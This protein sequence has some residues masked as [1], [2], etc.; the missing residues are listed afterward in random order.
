[1]NMRLYA[2][3]AL[4]VGA[5]CIAGPLPARAAYPEKPIRI[6]VPLAPGGTVDLVSRLLAKGLSDELGQSVIVENKPGASGLIGTR[7]VAHA[8]PDGYTLLAVANTF[9]SAPAFVPNA[10][11]DPL[12]D[13]APITQTCQIPMVLVAHPSVPQ[14]TVKELIERARAHPG[15][16]SFASSGIGSTGY[17]AAEL[18]SRQAGI[19]LLGVAYKGNGQALTDVVGGQVMT[20]FDQV[21]TSGP[22][23]GTNKLRALA[24]TTATRSVLLPDVPTIAE[25]GLP[26][27]EDVTF[28]AILAP[29]GTPAAIV[30]QLHEAI[31]KVLAQPALREQLGGQGVEVKV[32][33]SPA[34]FGVYL[35]QAAQKY[36]GIA[37]NRPAGS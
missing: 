10:G 35:K 21:S 18:F 28:N 3:A 4:A 33:D 20:M 15:E 37:Q 34:A 24:V 1:M 19:E 32:S 22:Y 7:D 36:Q 26:G 6:V 27:Y 12:K 9:V 17:I 2:L 8:K 23:I 25:S 11:Y 5:A 29:A 14:R 16:V 13:F 30:A 31:G